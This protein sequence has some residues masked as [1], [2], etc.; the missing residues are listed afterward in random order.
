MP[1]DTLQTVKTPSKSSRRTA[2]PR[3]ITFTR[4]RDDLAKALI[5]ELDEKVF[6]NQLPQDIKIV[7]NG[8][9][10]TTAGRA[11]WKK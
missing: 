8:R 3:K 1:L 4:Q 10:N 2:S 7:W 9:L 11:S 5:Q 6:D